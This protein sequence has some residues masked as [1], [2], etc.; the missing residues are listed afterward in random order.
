MK[1]W[2]II[3]LILSVFAGASA[4]KQQTQ[5][6][7]QPK[8]ITSEPVL[9]DTIHIG[10]YILQLDTS[11]EADFL[12]LSS[13]VF[14]TSEQ[15]NLLRDSQWVKRN[16]DTLIFSTDRGD[17]VTL[18]NIQS[19]APDSFSVF[20]YKGR[21]NT[22]NHTLSMGMFYEWYYYLLINSFT[23]DTTDTW[24]WPEVS[25]NG[26]M[27]ISVN[28]DIEA[29]FT[30]NGIQIFDV[31]NGSIMLA[32]EKEIDYWG[33]EEVRWINNREAILKIL[34]LNAG[35]GNPYRYGYLRLTIR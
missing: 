12:K 21:L 1:T 17:Y 18:F 33:P 35:S 9:P 19:D 3:L 30:N 23:G 25:P 2:E 7:A 32:G 24:G 11:S 10:K 29:G 26:K 15:V 4:C 6:V 14:D 22:I 28:A 16:G 8:A 34:F 31:T 20:E 5:R 27:I 13:V